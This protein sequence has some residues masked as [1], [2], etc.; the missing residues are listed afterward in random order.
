MNATHKMQ[1]SSSAPLRRPPVRRPSLRDELSLVAIRYEKTSQGN[2]P[3]P[4]TT[5]NPIRSPSRPGSSASGSSSP[6]NSPVVVRPPQPGSLPPPTEE[7]PAFRQ[8][9]VLPRTASVDDWKRDSGHAAACSST[10]PTINEEECEND[11][12]LCEPRAT[13]TSVPVSPAVQ[14]HGAGHAE[15]SAQ[16][17]YHGEPAGSDEHSAD[18]MQTPNQHWSAS[19]TSVE[20][21]T[22]ATVVAS[23]PC[24]SQYSPIATEGAKQSP[25]PSSNTVTTIATTF[26]SLRSES[27][28]PGETE[29]TFTPS[30]K[31]VKTFSL[32][33]ASSL[34]GWTERQP[35]AQGSNRKSNHSFKDGTGLARGKSL[36]H[37]RSSHQRPLRAPVPVVAMKPEMRGGPAPESANEPTESSAD[38]TS[39]PTTSSSSPASHGLGTAAPKGKA[40]SASFWKRP[41][42]SK[43]QSR[44]G[45]DTDDATEFLPLEVSL[46]SQS[47]L[48]DDF[49]AGFSFSKRGSVMFGGQRALAL[50]AAIMDSHP[51]QLPAKT[52]REAL[53]PLDHVSPIA[54]PVSQSPRPVSPVSNATSDTGFVTPD[55]IPTPDPNVQASQPPASQ[56]SQ[57]QQK[58]ESQSQ[59]LPQPR[60]RPTHLAP[61]PD[62]RVME[63]DVDKESQK[64]RS[65]YAAGDDALRW[66]DGALPSF[67]E[68]PTHAPIEEVSGEEDGRDP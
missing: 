40:A 32:R 19:F 64:V 60:P 18:A 41:F 35:G 14:Q 1:R 24:S 42:T 20:S 12:L 21:H 31:L 43:S 62:I 23:D 9:S 67:E 65:L 13:N 56:E 52:S 53:S 17:E 37:P 68:K 5:I 10:T 16:E 66:E 45:S 48:D 59:S 47:L 57:H 30:Q 4:I 54:T 22:S 6:S 27:T 2:A 50:D 51:H 44:R 11:I 39:T 34:L 15:V 58:H 26:S 46:P 36:S 7:H 55:V 28:E 49:L 61:P 38:P 8:G 33:S 29:T 3:I 63:A 25:L